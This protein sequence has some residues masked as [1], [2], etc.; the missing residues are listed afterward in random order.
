MSAVDRGSCI[1]MTSAEKRRGLYSVQRARLDIFAKSISQPEEESI[2]TIC[3]EAKEKRTDVGSSNNI[4][5]L[6]LSRLH[7]QLTQ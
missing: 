3:K 6:Q 7:R 4:L 1:R 2:H 5:Y